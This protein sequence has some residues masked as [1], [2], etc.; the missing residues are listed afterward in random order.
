MMSLVFGLTCGQ[1]NKQSIDKSTLVGSWKSSIHFQTGSL[2]SIKDLEFMYAFNPGGTMTESSNY[3][4]APP[5]PP[6]YGIWKS[7]GSN[8]YEARYEFY[9]TRTPT[10]AEAATA[11]GGWLPGGH[12]LLFETITI[13]NDG[14]SFSSKIRYDVFDQTGKPSVGGG[15]GTA[16]AARMI[17]K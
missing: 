3:D 2:A 16:Q 5:V 13:A 10:P 15:T 4:A 11:S 17:F 8:Q 9:I 14:N 7:S 12:G 6:A 1:S